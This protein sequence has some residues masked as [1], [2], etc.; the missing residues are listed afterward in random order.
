ME[1]GRLTN[2]PLLLC[3]A[4]FIFLRLAVWAGWRVRKWRKLPDSDH[5]DF[6][7][8]L[9]A[10][11][12]LLGLIVGFTFSMA[13]SRYDQR[14]N[15]EE[16]E[17]NAIGTE[18]VRAELLPAADAG[19]VTALLRSYLDQRIR[20][21][22]SNR[23]TELGQINARTTELQNQLWAAVRVPATV[24]PNAPL[25]LV[26]AGMNDVI[27]RQGYTQA[28]WWNRIPVAAW[29]LMFGIALSCNFLFG[30]GAHR[31]QA[32]GAMYSVLPFL[33]ALSFMLIADIDSP[34]G[35]L[36]RVNPQNLI[37]LSQSLQTDESKGTRP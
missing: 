10:A 28:A 27:N 23:W 33:I 14:K 9:T 2:F 16:E 1:L 22:G 13:V 12:T 8:I 15:Y 3:L 6:G 29:V 35:G 11:L 18:Y 17:A 21:Y 31:T 24:Q 36:I 4:T 32:K 37:S 5:E 30:Y 7:T 20:F 34:R 19:R 26:L 25:A